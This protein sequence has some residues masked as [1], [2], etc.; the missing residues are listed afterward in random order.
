MAFVNDVQLQKTF[1][2]VNNYSSNRG[3]KTPKKLNNVFCLLIFFAIL[4]K[5]KLK[6]DWRK[7]PALHIYSPIIEKNVGAI[8]NNYYAIANFHCHLICL[9][10]DWDAKNCFEET[11]A[12]MSISFDLRFLRNTLTI[13]NGVTAYILLK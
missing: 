2:S 8:I 5:Q 11:K 7:K 6:F 12:V 10:N 13:F 1:K 3:R 9:A 4:L